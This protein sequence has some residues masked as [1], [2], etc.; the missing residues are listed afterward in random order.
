MTRFKSTMSRRTVRI[1]CVLFSGALAIPIS[2]ALPEP[3]VIVLCG[4]L[5]DELGPYPHFDADPARSV[6]HRLEWASDT[7]T[8]LTIQEWE[9]GEP[10]CAEDPTNCE[11]EFKK[12]E[13]VIIGGDASVYCRSNLGTVEG[14]WGKTSR[15]ELHAPADVFDYNCF[16]TDGSGPAPP[17]WAGN[18]QLFPTC[19]T[20]NRYKLNGDYTPNCKR[21]IHNP[22]DPS[23]PVTV[24]STGYFYRTTF[25]GDRIRMHTIEIV[26][27]FYQ[28]NPDTAPCNIYTT[29]NTPQVGS[30]FKYSC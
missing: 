14:H 27:S 11:P 10:P 25:S 28:S 12:A 29:G 4:S 9:D 19:E 2:S 24:H 15:T 1:L 16:Y 8:D 13:T 20:F 18:A 26:V 7:T 21:V 5:C 6:H 17:R 22:S 23:Q 30:S 3:N